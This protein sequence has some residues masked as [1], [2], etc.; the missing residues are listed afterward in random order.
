VP[1]TIPPVRVPKASNGTR[2]EDAEPE[3]G[4]VLT[5]PGDDGDSF[6]EKPVPGTEQPGPTP[7]GNV[8]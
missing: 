8:S 7:P 4:V 3:G 1:S 2:A 6:G 5:P